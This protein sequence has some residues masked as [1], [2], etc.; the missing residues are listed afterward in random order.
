MGFV[1]GEP[2]PYYFYKYWKR[3]EGDSEKKLFAAKYSAKYASGAGLY[4]RMSNGGRKKRKQSA[5]PGRIIEPKPHTLADSPGIIF[6]G[7]SFKG[8]R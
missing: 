7:N 4:Q 6:S 5:V 2:N 1:S 8:S 3:L